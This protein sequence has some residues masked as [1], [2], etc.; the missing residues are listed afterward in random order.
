MELIK[1]N[2]YY[3]NFAGQILNGRFLESK[4]LIDGTIVYKFVDSK[5]SIYPIRKENVAIQ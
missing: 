3:F 1:N 2:L 4:Q 5:G